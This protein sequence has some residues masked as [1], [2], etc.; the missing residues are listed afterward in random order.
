LFSQGNEL[1]GSPGHRWS[2]G[3][4]E[5]AENGHEGRKRPHRASPHRR[6]KRERNSAPTPPASA[7]AEAA[8]AAQQE[9]GQET[10]ADPS[11]YNSGD[12]HGP[13]PA[14]LTESDWLEVPP[15]FL[16]CSNYTYKLSFV[17]MERNFGKKLSKKGLMIREMDRDGACLFRAVADQ[18]Y[19]DQE[20]HQ[21]VR[22]NC[23]DYLVGLLDS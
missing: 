15:W 19:G 9:S 5:E 21:A 10:D 1:L 16:M 2:P 12:E 3:L 7:P 6:P 14:L 17:Q 23:M 11:G 8:A 4:R 18:V 13:E 20:M 22:K